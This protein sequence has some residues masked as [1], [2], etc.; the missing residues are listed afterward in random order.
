MQLRGDL[1]KRDLLQQRES[2]P[3]RF[4]LALPRTRRL[5]EI[6]RANE[7]VLRAAL[8]LSS[9]QVWSA[10]R[11]GRPLGADGLLWLPPTGVARLARRTAA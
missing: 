10:L 5:R 3:V 11:S 9:R 8:P 6:V 4:V 2:R 7:S 1:L